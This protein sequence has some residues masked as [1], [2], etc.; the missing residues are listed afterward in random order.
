M[1]EHGVLV[2]SM[3]CGGDEIHAM[4]DCSTDPDVDQQDDFV[5]PWSYE[6]MPQCTEVPDDLWG[7]FDMTKQPQKPPDWADMLANEVVRSKLATMGVFIRAEQ[8]PDKVKD[9][10]TTK[11]DYDWTVFFRSFSWQCGDELATTQQTGS[12]RTCV[13]GEA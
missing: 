10:L 6:D 11:F 4:D 13:H 9:S 7:D 12:H 3:Q 1:E 2:N 8:Y 5:G